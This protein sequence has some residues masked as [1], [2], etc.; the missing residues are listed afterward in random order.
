MLKVSGGSALPRVA[1]GR[2]MSLQYRLGPRRSGKPLQI[3][4]AHVVR[5]FEIEATGQA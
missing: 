4:H 5:T 1:Q 2:S 3:R